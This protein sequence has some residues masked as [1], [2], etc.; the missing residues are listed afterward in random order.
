[1]KNFVQPGDTVTVTA[2]TGGVTSGS[3]VLIGGLFGIDAFDA[4]EGNEVEIATR[5]VFQLPKAAEAIDAGNR[6]YFDPALGVVTDSDTTE[7][8]LIGACIKDAESGDASCLVR[9]DGVSMV[10]TGA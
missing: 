10:L 3:G 4:A 1:M 5:G 8:A 9:L 7:T 6:V 2:P